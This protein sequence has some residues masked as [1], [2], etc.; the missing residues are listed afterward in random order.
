MS[1]E[2]WDIDGTWTLFLDRDGVINQRIM[3]GYVTDI[4]SFKFESGALEAIVT[5][6]SIFHL[7]IV[8][9]N[10]QGIGK[11]LM[12]ERNLIDI[13]TYMKDKV[14]V[15]GGRIDKCFFAPNL[16]GATD[17]MRKPGPAMAELA[18]MEFPEIEY[19]R[20]VMIGDTDSDILFGKNLGMKTVRVK[21]EESIGVE[22]DLSVESL[23]EFA[24]MLKNEI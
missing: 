18:K 14:H 19:S 1:I 10:Q 17:D 23:V 3:E 6:S 4:D 20:C 22:A 9:T 8:V 12:S 11:G 16:K 21:T 24:K 13:H 15:E 7:L 5:L 2:N